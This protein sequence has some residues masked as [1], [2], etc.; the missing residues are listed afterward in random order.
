[1]NRYFNGWAIS[2]IV[3]LIIIIIQLLLPDIVPDAILNLLNKEYYQFV[4]FNTM[5]QAFLLIYIMGGWVSF[6]VG[7]IGWAVNL[8]S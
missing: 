1:M 3:G 5:L 7:L 4:G 8:K 2:A 6:F